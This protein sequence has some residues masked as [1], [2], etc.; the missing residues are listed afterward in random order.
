M[1]TRWDQRIQELE[2]KCGKGKRVGHIVVVPGS[3]FLEDEAGIAA[4]EEKALGENPAPE[5]AIVNPILSIV[6]IEA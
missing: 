2:K 3:F 1:T 4:A 5:N 6:F